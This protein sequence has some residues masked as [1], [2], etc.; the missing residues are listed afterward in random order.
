M[1]YSGDTFS[2]LSGFIAIIITTAPG[3]IFYPLSASRIAHL[4]VNTLNQ[5]I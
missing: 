3:L 2:D 5:A 4:A 1:N